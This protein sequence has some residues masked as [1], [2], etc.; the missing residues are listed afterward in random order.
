MSIGRIRRYGGSAIYVHNM[1]G[2]VN[3]YMADGRS[4]KGGHGYEDGKQAKQA[5]QQADTA[6]G[7]NADHR[8][9]DW[10]EKTSGGHGRFENTIR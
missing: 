10:S 3:L 9:K 5:D 6:V 7:A 2:K 4:D 8:A 1:I